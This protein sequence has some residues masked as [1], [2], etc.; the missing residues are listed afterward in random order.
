MAKH[1]G[2]IIREDFNASNSDGESVIIC[3]ALTERD[4]FGKSIVEKVWNL[5]TVQKR[6]EFFER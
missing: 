4:E 2:C 3:A 1:L 6:I 5:D